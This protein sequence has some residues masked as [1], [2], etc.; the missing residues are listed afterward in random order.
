MAVRTPENNFYSLHGIWGAY[1]SLALGRFGK[2][3]GVVIGDVHP[4]RSGLLIGYRTGRK[5]PRI[6]PFTSGQVF[7]PQVDA[8]I[9][10][11]TDQIHSHPRYTSLFLQ[12]EEIERWVSFS[13]EEWK[14]GPMSMR[15]YSFFGAVP[16]PRHSSRSEARSA[17][18]P[19]L[20]IKLS[21]DNTTGSGEMTGVFGMQGIR[22]PLSDSTHGGLLGMARGTSYGFATLPAEGV[23]EVMD[24]SF[25]EAAFNGGFDGTPRPLRRLACEGGLSFKIGAGEAKSFIIALGIYR[26]GIITSGKPSHAYYTSLYKN[27]EE[28]LEDALAESDES[29]RKAE[30]LDTELDS[31][32]LSEDRKFILAHAAHSYLANTELLLTEDGEPLFVVN[33]G[34]YQMMNTLDL[35]IDQAFWETRFSPW[36]VRNELEFYLERY[37]YQDSLGIC[38]THDQ[39]VADCFT[40]PGK[41][42]YE[43]P[44]LADCFSYMS[45]EETL[46]WT[47]TACLYA[48]SSND[49]AWAVS[50]RNTFAS[51]LASI[52][53]RDANGDGVMD[54][55]SDRCEGGAEITTYD[56]IDISLGQARN[57]LYTAVKAWATYVCLEAFFKRIDGCVSP[58]SKAAADSARL[59]AQ[60]ISEK[61]LRDELF[62]PAVFEADNR[63][64]IIPAV[65]G[66]AY[67]GFCG[68][69]EAL[70]PEGPYGALIRA[71]TRH[72]DTVLAPGLCLDPVSG[73][74]KLSSSDK[75]TWISK[76]ILNQYV[77][78]NILGIV[79]ERTQRDKIHAR[80]LRTGC[81]DF[82]ATDQIDSET[83][84]D[85][86]SRLYPRLVTAILWLTK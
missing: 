71:L 75:N 79:D 18:R 51:C 7:G 33:E 41:S 70:R 44:R 16:D 8:Y 29:I 1:A 30:V 54:R 53:S 19:S 11:N 63:S 64:C 77:V 78:E 20:L 21:F 57:N 76:I 6:F 86:G 9:N 48:S 35:T 34:E 31:S 59:I 49:T 23:F 82:A 61:L 2:G 15:I 28:V 39:G 81:A 38:F 43:M 85:L 25:I 62:I 67:P 40:A 42:A 55:D 14:S 32:G 80:W 56:S 69:A 12:D 10:E 5:E 72:I 66:L 73:G 68:A 45:Y 24:W 60:T 65:E 50:R 27:L 17:L 22:R 36:T 46:N 3:A 52:R 47:L 58:E 4:P 74:W 84:R 37:S 26:D 83:G 13:G